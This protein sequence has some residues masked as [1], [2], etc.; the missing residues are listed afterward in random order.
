[1]DGGSLFKTKSF[2]AILLDLPESWPKS[3]VGLTQLTP[4]RF[5]SSRY[6]LPGYDGLNLDGLDFPKVKT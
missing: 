5:A 2:T 3:A 1:M 6:L 4:F